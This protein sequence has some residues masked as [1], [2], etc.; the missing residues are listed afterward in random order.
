MGIHQQYHMNSSSYLNND[1][2]WNNPTELD[3]LEMKKS[4]IIT[5][6]Q[7]QNYFLRVLPCIRKLYTIFDSIYPNKYR[8]HCSDSLRTL[9]EIICLTDEYMHVF[10]SSTISTNELLFNEKHFDD[11]ISKIRQPIFIP[12]KY[13]SSIKT[14]LHC[15][16]RGIQSYHY[17]NELNQTSLFCFELTTI[18]INLPLPIN[19]CIFDPDENLV[20]HDVKYINTYNQGYTQL[21]SCSYTPRT[22]SGMYRISLFCD[23]IKI[24]NQQY[25]VFIRNNSYPKK[26]ENIIKKPESGILKIIFI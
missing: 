21:F 13:Y 19:I 6:P 25:M 17:T 5:R 2:V 1:F 7:N 20:S 23:N 18:K 9:N 15:F 24:T 26:E 10:P 14:E 11:F 8:I 12:K 4:S 22:R 16:G 3:L